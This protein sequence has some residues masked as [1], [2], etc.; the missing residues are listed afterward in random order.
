M[1]SIDFQFS[2]ELLMTEMFYHGYKRIQQLHLLAL[3]L[4]ILGY[5]LGLLKGSEH[6]R[7]TGGL[8]GDNLIN[9]FLQ[10]ILKLIIQ[11]MSLEAEYKFKGL[12]LTEGKVK[13]QS[14]SQTSKGKMVKHILTN[15][16]ITG[17]KPSEQLFPKQVSTQIPLLK[18]VAKQSLR[19]P[20]SLTHSS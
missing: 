12:I 1:R 2:S 10:R 20:S 4:E 6:F 18:L 15:K 5:I 9:V 7:R 19:K 3:H 13:P 17:D 11:G 16:T 14:L 8:I